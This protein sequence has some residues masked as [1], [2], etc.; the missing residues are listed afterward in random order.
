MRE[1]PKVTEERVIH[2]MSRQ[3]VV[4]IMNGSVT[5]EGRRLDCGDGKH[6]AEHGGDRGAFF[7]CRCGAM[8]RLE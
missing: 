1:T 8:F 7:C 6:C 4:K 2:G 5:V 3:R